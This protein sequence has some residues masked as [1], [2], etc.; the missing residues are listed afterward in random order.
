MNMKFTPKKHKQKITFCVF[1]PKTS[2]YRLVT[3]NH[4]VNPNPLICYKTPEQN[5][6]VK[7]MRDKERNDLGQRR[8]RKDID[9]M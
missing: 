6:S 8:L 2:N 9:P 5:L 1:F 4:Q 7:V 3:R